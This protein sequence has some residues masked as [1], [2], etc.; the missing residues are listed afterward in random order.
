MSRGLAGGLGGLANN[1]ST[2]TIRG[3]PVSLA[4]AAVSFGIGAIGAQ[5]D[6]A[7]ALEFQGSAAIAA[8][9]VAGLA[10]AGADTTA[11]EAIDG[12]APSQSISQ[13][14]TVT[15]GGPGITGTTLVSDPNN[16]PY[17]VVF[18]DDPNLYY[19]NPTLD[20]PQ[21]FSPLIIDIP[22]FS[23]NDGSGGD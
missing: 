17:L 12:E 14:I 1:L 9:T 21:N 2:S 20:N 3:K 23:P 16:Q 13:D 7:I 15:N 6:P 18:P 22:D 10:T 4:S 19:H 5:A 8:S 11:T